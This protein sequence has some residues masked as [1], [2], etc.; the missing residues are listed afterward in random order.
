MSPANRK[1]AR[2]QLPP[3]LELACLNTLWRLGEATVREVQQA[4]L[5]RHDLAYTTVLT[6]LDR[7]AR[8]GIVERNLRG[9][10]FVYAPAVSRDDLRRAA[11]RE[12]LDNYFDG[13]AAALLAFLAREEA[14]PPAAPLTAAT[15]DPALL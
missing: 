6:V 11:V 10:R 1:R 14:P 4:L 7:L 15:L 2:R 5:P 8:K 12:L 13:S 9:R 3:P